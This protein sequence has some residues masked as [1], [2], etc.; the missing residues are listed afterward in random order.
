MRAQASTAPL[1]DEHPPRRGETKCRVI[2]RYAQRSADDPQH[3]LAGANTEQK[4]LGA[5]QQQE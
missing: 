3:H 5:H 4:E 1:A 2:Q